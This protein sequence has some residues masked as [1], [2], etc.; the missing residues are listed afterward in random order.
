M[1]SL[2]K[3]FI[4]TTYDTDL[5]GSLKPYS[6]MNYFQEIASR[7]AANL[8]FGYDDLRENIIFWALSRMLVRINKMPR[9]NEE[10]TLE[11]W[12]MRIDKIFAMRG[13]QLC[14]LAGEVLVDAVSAWLALNLETRRP[15][16]IDKLM[17][18]VEWLTEKGNLHATPD[19]I[20]LP[21]MN[22]SFTHKVNYSD[23]DVNRH[24]SNSKYVE[25]A[26]DAASEKIEIENIKEYQINYTKEAK[27]GDA[28]DLM[29][30]D[31]NENE[32]FVCGVNQESEQ[33]HFEMKIIF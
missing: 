8:N 7:N 21:E 15:S 23:I 25:W 3:K 14:D 10:F 2:K 11:T 28:I 16:R 13:F 29:V 18:D 12:P 22:K 32:L 33:K 24:V 27:L 26:I 19:K 20:I 1:S 6:L 4:A 9:W 5:N 30:S 17:K 31:L